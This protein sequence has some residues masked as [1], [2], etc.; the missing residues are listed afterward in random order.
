MTHQ[1][2]SVDVDGAER[3]VTADSDPETGK[4]VVRVDGRLVAKPLSPADREREFAVGSSRYSVRRSADGGFDLD[5]VSQEVAAVHPTL[6][7]TTPL[8]ERRWTTGR[9]V[10]AI[11]GIVVGLFIARVA[12]I[13]AQ[14]MRVPWKTYASP[15][16]AFKAIFP[17]DPTEET[18]DLNLKGDI[19]SF[20]ML[21]GTYRAHTY[22]LGYFDAHMV[23]VEQNSD[24]LLDRFLG[25][26]A[27]GE[28]MVLSSKQKT[29]FRRDHAL[30]FTADVPK[31]EEHGTAAARG[32]LVL[33]G[34]RFYMIWTIV[35]VGQTSAYDVEKFIKG[36]DLSE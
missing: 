30:D 10:W 13:S 25:G 1:A 24:S 3:S 5:F 14:Y 26:V 18:E 36:F 8:P 19:W 31:T 17:G 16:G 35:P 15:D 12:W 11:V 4:T 21:H 27:S 23:V 7:G 6:Q 2:W 28:K 33:H 20:H 29:T 32:R 34:R 9:I 22:V